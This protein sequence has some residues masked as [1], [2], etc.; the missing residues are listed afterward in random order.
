MTRYKCRICD[1]TFD[2]PAKDRCDGSE[3]CPFCLAPY[4]DE[5]DLFPCS[6]CGGD[7]LKGE[8]ICKSCGENLVGKFKS[9][10]KDLDLNDNENDYLTSRI[11][12][13]GL[14]DLLEG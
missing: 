1:A 2:E 9:K 13:Y 3:T 4:F 7:K 6:V 8:L 10:L 14:L 12:E 11:C 5:L